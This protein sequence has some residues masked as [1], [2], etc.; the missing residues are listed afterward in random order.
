MGL[1]FCLQQ[2]DAR[3][4]CY[5]VDW[6]DT[7][8]FR[9]HATRLPQDGGHCRSVILRPFSHDSARPRSRGAREQSSAAAYFRIRHAR[10]TPVTVPAAFDTAGR[11]PGF[12]ILSAYL[13]AR[14]DK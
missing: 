10:F 7:P 13:P 9:C 1:H 3:L 8:L 6:P 14:Q 12:A 5:F 11:R 4:F 2:G